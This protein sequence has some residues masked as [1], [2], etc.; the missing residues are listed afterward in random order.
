MSDTPY[1]GALVV[2]ALAFLVGAVISGIRFVK[3]GGKPSHAIGLALIGA[4]A[5]VVGWVASMA[6]TALSGPSFP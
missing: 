6:S 1:A 5:V 4:L 2:M 3:G